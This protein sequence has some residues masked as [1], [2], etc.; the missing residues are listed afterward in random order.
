MAAKLA[1]QCDY[2]CDS[3]HGMEIITLPEL[4]QC[5]AVNTE[6]QKLQGQIISLFEKRKRDLE[7]VTII[8]KVNNKILFLCEMSC[9]PLVSFAFLAPSKIMNTLCRI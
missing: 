9:S 3:K 8:I 5:F 6:Q 2:L 4:L 7:F 1:L